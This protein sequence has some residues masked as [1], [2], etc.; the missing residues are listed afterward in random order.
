MRQWVVHK[1]NNL[2]LILGTKSGK[3]E[4]TG[5]SYHLIPTF[6]T[7]NTSTPPHKHTDI[8]KAF[9]EAEGINEVVHHIFEALSLTLNTK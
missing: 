2:S 1:P 5:K 7:Y 8:L 4:L 3:R 6:V 9:K